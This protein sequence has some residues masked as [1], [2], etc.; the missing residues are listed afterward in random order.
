MPNAGDCGG[1]GPLAAE[2]CCTMAFVAFMCGKNWRST[3]SRCQPG[4]RRSSRASSSCSTACG[5]RLSPG[6]RYRIVWI[7]HL[8]LVPAWQRLS[9]LPHTAVARSSGHP[10]VVVR[11]GAAMRR[12]G[13]LVGRHCF[14]R[15]TTQ[16]CVLAII[17]QRRGSCWVGRHDHGF[18]R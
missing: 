12:R 10:G 9:V 14:L 5:S 6:S 16:G 15:P 11:A 7:E 1:R 17:H 2:P 4:W 13:R 18:C 3:S 8:P